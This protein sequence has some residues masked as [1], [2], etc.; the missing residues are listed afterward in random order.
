MWAAARPSFAITSVVMGNCGFTIAESAQMV[1][2]F[3]DALAL[4]MGAGLFGGEGFILQR[5]RGDGKAFIH[6]GANSFGAYQR[7]A[8]AYGFG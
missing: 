2:L 4:E 5:L 6:A 1:V 8:R 3:D 7:C